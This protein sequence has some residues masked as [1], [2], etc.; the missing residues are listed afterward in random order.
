MEFEPLPAGDLQI[1]FSYVSD[2]FCGKSG[3]YVLRVVVKH[4]NGLDDWTWADNI[5]NMIDECGE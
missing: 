4:P 2:E 1:G 5:A 3:V